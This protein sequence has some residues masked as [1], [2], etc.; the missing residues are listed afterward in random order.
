MDGELIELVGRQRLIA[1]LLGAGEIA[2]SIRDRRK[3]FIA[4]AD[5]RVAEYQAFPIQ[6]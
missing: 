1:E 3:D 2:I 6:I 5:L 4:Y